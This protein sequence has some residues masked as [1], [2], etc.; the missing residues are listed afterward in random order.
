MGK[1]KSERRSRRSFFLPS[2]RLHE[3]FLIASLTH[4]SRTGANL[5]KWDFPSTRRF[6]PLSFL[7][8]F[9]PVYS[10]PFPRFFCRE[11]IEF[12]RRAAPTRAATLFSPFS[13]LCAAAAFLNG[14]S[15]FRGWLR[16]HCPPVFAHANGRGYTPSPPFLRSLSDERRPIYASKRPNCESVDR[17]NGLAS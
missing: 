11:K 12:E 14:G 13:L 10:P 17:K 4:F 8:S 16:L 5:Q 3:N 1:K 9:R 7:P 2:T 6:Q 15:V